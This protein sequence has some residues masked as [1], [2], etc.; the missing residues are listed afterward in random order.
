MVEDTSRE[1]RR[2][3][4]VDWLRPPSQTVSFL[5]VREVSSDSRGA[6]EGNFPGDFTRNGSLRDPNSAQPPCAPFPSD[7]SFALQESGY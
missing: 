7:L 2:G 5:L 3:C 1:A 6:A 4:C